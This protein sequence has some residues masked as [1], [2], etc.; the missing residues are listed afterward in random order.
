MH[1]LI[2]RALKDFVLAHDGAAAWHRVTRMIDIPPEDFGLFRV[3]DKRR[4]SELIR[5]IALELDRPLADFCEDWGHWLIASPGHEVTRRLLRFGGKD[6]DEFVHSIE[7]LPDRAALAVP[8]LS[9]PPVEVRDH[10][11]G[12]F[13]L[14][15]GTRMPGTEHVLLGVLRAM[16]DDYGCLV[17]MTHLGDR[18][19]S[20][21]MSL[22]LVG[23]MDEALRGSAEGAAA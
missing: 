6:F 23:G 16:A 12:H 3:T 21:M 15:V 9:L 19:S 7:D 13:T 14:E 2:N 10:G 17:V 22:Q 1:G 8:G 4:T 18:G 11:S 5:A 20:A